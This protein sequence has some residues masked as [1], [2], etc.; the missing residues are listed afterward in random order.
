MIDLHG[1]HG[2][3]GVRL[4]SCYPVFGDR[5][6]S[7]VVRPYSNVVRAPRLQLTERVRLLYLHD[8]RHRYLLSYQKSMLLQYLFCLLKHFI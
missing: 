6:T 7:V 5:E 8:K 3:A 1:W 4:Q 2:A